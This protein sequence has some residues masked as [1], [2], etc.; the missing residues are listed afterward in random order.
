ME[1]SQVTNE[2]LDLI[3]NKQIVDV[4]EDLIN[5]D[6]CKYAKSCQDYANGVRYKS[7]CTGYEGNEAKK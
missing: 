6:N 5:C 2:N 7:F 3:N 1:N 4:R